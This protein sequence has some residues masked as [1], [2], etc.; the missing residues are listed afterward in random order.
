VAVSANSQVVIILMLLLFIVTMIIVTML[1]P[2]T[3]DDIAVPKSMA[4][5]REAVDL[6]SNL[7]NTLVIR[8]TGVSSVLVIV[9]Q[10]TSMWRM[11]A[12]VSVG[13]I[14]ALHTL[15]AA[16]G[17]AGGNLKFFSGDSGI[18]KRDFGKPDRK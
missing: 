18:L 10:S 6:I 2:R 8:A 16:D 15:A 7:K 12:H 11:S 5:G 1:V 9:G 17:L 3:C 14:P 4:D 13:S